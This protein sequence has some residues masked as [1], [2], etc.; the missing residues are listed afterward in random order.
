MPVDW[1]SGGPELL[2]DVRHDRGALGQQI[3]DRLRAAM[4]AADLAEAMRC[5]V[6]MHAALPDRE[7]LD[8]NLVLVG[9]GGGKDSSYV[10]AFVRT[11]Q[12]ILFRVHGSTFRLRVVTNRHAGMPRAVLENIEKTFA[13]MPPR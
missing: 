11:V 13:A 12:L 6:R 9:Y 4:P 1:R 7:R 2:L 3:Q 10:L 5:A 8:R